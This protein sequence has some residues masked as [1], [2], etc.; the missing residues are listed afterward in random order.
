MTFPDSN[1]EER[2]S[3]F[4]SRYLSYE[5]EG[6]KDAAV[7]A[8]I[9]A[10]LQEPSW[11][12]DV[13]AERTVERLSR[14]INAQRRVH[15]SKKVPESVTLETG[16]ADMQQVYQAALADKQYAPAIKAK[17]TQFKLLGFLKPDGPTLNV[18]INAKMLSDDQLQQIAAGKTIDAEYSE[19]EAPKQLTQERG[20]GSL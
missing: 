4:I 9:D 16:V 10:R 3:I 17:E 18:N 19:V 8:C 12:I 5:A 13:T 14:Q 1:T 20:L 6:R 2:D 11:P 7:R 15:K